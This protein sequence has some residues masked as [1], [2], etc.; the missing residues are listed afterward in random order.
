MTDIFDQLVI[1]EEGQ[2]LAVYDDA[3]GKPGHP[4][5]GRGRAL[6]TQGIS[7][8]EMLYLYQNDKQRVLAA[9]LNALP[10][11]THLA[12][13]RLGVLCA[14]AFQIG[15]AGLLEFH[16]TLAA[17]KDGNWQAAHDGMLDSVWAKQTPLRAQRMA[18]KILT[19]TDPTTI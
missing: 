7:Q 15:I 3:T 17:I 13:L 14:M 10:W 12:P 6:D 2:R 4:T 19:N 16:Q 8:E 11:A 1:P 5:I 9:V 18:S